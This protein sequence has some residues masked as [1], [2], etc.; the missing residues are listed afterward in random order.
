MARTKRFNML[1]AQLTTNKTNQVAVEA[2][3]LAIKQAYVNRDTEMALALLNDTPQ[4]IRK[5]L[6]SWFRHYGLLVQDPKIGESAYT[7][8]AD[9][10]KDTKRQHKVFTELASA[11]VKPVFVEEIQI[12]AAKVKK[13]LKG[14]AKERAARKMEAVIKSLRKDDDEAATYVADTW[15]AKAAET[16]LAFE[17]GEVFTLSYTEVAAVRNFILQMR[18]EM[19]K[20]A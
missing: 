19:K 13:P 5:A 11:D 7:I 18:G 4:F 9:V 17:D 15:A 1:H 14:T 8:G 20:A 6:S 12:R 16:D 10:I 2:G 3:T